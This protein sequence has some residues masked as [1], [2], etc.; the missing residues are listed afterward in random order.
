[1]KRKKVVDKVVSTTEVAGEAKK[2]V[3]I[4]SGKPSNDGESRST[5]A[6]SPKNPPINL[7]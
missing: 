5:A 2:V 7:Y 1:M 4:I 3:D 6:N